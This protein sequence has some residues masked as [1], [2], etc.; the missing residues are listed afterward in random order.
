MRPDFGIKIVELDGM[1]LACRYIAPGLTFEDLSRIF[2]A[3]E[4]AAEPSDHLAG[5]PMKWPDNR[6]I[7][8]VT[9]AILSAIYGPEGDSN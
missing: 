7:H 6:G 8:A 1:S 5:D 4:D 9:E 3:A 2:H